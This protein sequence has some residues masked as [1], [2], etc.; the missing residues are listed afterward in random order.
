MG[1]KL[2]DMLLAPVE[3][4]PLHDGAYLD[5]EV[6]PISFLVDILRMLRRSDRA[7]IA[8]DH[9]TL[10]WMA[11]MWRL[12]WSSA[13]DETLRDQIWREHERCKW[14]AKKVAEGVIDPDANGSCFVFFDSPEDWPDWRTVVAAIR[15]L[16]RA[17]V[18]WLV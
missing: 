10:Q 7:E 6:R 5:I 17:E 16:Q 15:A 8:F 2:N 13:Q 1:M 12:A 3:R 4:A 11:N 9:K 18:Q 14:W